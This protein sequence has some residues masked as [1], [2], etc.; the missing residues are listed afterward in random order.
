MWL[1]FH[2]VCM[3]ICTF[4][5]TLA[6]MNIMCSTEHH[7]RFVC[8][9]VCLCVC[10]CLSVCVCLCAKELSTAFSLMPQFCLQALWGF[11]IATLCFSLSLAIFYFSFLLLC[12]SVRLLY[13]SLA[14]YLYFTA[15]LRWTTRS[16]GIRTW[17]LSL[18]TRPYWTSS[19]RTWWCMSITLA[20]RPWSFRRAERFGATLILHHAIHF[21]VHSLTLHSQNGSSDNRTLL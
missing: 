7:F 19:G 21:T 15:R 4:L 12:S 14:F 1:P 11:L 8:L 16:S 9:H 13:L 3:D 18:K 20:T 5:Y 6:L 10:V 17:Q 2:T